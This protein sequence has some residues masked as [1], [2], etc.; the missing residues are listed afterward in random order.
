MIYNSEAGN[1]I[2][3]KDGTKSIGGYRFARDRGINTYI[4]TVGKAGKTKDVFIA[5]KWGSR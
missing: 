2:D 3:G 5:R 4:Q 1:R